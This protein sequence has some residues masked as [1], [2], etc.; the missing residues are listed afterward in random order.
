MGTC[1][2]GDISLMPGHSASRRS[3]TSP[4]RSTPPITWMFDFT[5]G[6]SGR[7]SITT[8]SS[9]SARNACRAALGSSLTITRTGSI[10]SARV[11]TFSMKSRSPTSSAARRSMPSWSSST[12][13]IS[14]PSASTSWPLLITADCVHSRAKPNAAHAPWR[15]LPVV[16]A[17]VTP[18]ACARLMAAMAWSVARVSPK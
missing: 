11:I 17:N 12:W 9:L 3:R 4:I 1:G 5:S 16:A 2:P 14:C 13:P 8:T 10:V 7:W 6:P 18:A 15:I